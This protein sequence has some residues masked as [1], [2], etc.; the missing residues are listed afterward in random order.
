MWALK[1]SLF[2]YELKYSKGINNVHSDCFSRLSLPETTHICE[3]YEL[4]C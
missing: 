1:L 2:D 3:P 4:V